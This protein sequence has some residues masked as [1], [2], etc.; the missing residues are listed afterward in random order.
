MQISDRIA[1]V[2]RRAHALNLSLRKACMRAG[3]DYGNIFRWRGG[4]SDPQAPIFEQTMSRLE[5][6]LTTLEA[7]MLADLQQKV[8][9]SRPRHQR[10]SA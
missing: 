4:S 10:R 3:V 9:P 7:A 5:A 8:A 2:E 1:S 6:E